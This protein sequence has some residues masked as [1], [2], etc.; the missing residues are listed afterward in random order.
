MIRRLLAAALSAATLTLGLV[1]VTSAPA[2]AAGGWTIVSKPSKR[3]IAPSGNNTTDRNIALVLSS[4][5]CRITWN[6]TIGPDP[7]GDLYY[8]K[9]DANSNRCWYPSGSSLAPGIKIV[10]GACFST[11]PFLWKPVK[12]KTEGGRDWYMWQ[13]Y[14][15]LHCLTVD[16]PVTTAGSPLVQRP[17]S[18]YDIHLFS[19]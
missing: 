9:L 1:V 18:G 10:T 13:S 11:P 17:C 12:Y 14:L 19:C 16:P 3:C 6:I 7:T 8:V 4:S 2:M 5:P 15:S